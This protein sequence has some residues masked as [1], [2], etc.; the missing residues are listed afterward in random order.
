M[1]M[2]ALFQPSIMNSEIVATQV[3]DYFVTEGV[4][5]FFFFRNGAFY[6]V[7]HPSFPR[8]YTFEILLL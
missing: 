8:V 3:C 2:C 4:P 5:F 6:L 1:Y 7:E